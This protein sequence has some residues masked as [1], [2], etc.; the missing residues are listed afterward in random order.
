MTVLPRQRVNLCAWMLVVSVFVLEATLPQTANVTLLYVV[1]LLLGLWTP[2]PWDVLH[3]AGLATALSSLA[4]ALSPY[5]WEAS[6]ISWNHGLE[7]IVVWITAF[8]VNLFRRTLRQREEAERHAREADARAREQAALA[9]IGKMATIV[10]HEVRNPL[11]GIRGA[12]QMIGRRL[13]PGT[14][15]GEVIA[16]VVARID[17]LNTMLT[18]LIDFSRAKG[19]PEQWW[20][21]TRSPTGPAAPS[22]PEGR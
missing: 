5:A 10:A 3:I 12:V 7:L 2:A 11:T 9:Q 1:V 20:T 15:E 21:Q 19:S 6:I 13:G 8:G 18:D 14:R 16:E 4:Y 17:R 22:T